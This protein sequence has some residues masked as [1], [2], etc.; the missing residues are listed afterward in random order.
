MFCKNCGAKTKEDS[1]FCQG[2]GIEIKYTHKIEEKDLEIIPK[3]STMG[4]VDKIVNIGSIIIGFVLGKFLGLSIFIYIIPFFI[5]QWF[6]KWYLKRQKINI[7]LIKFI[8]W[9]NVVTWLLPPLGILTGFT[10]LGF[11]NYFPG[12]K[13]KYKI[14]AIV[15]I[16]LS[17]INSFIGILM[18]I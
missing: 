6:P 17:L 15:G 7:G 4:V 8:V 9:S 12:E 2:C 3:I 10:T 16:T 1:K 18:K 14:L 11:S 5:G 13:K